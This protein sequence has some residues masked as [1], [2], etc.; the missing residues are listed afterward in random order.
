[1]EEKQKGEMSKHTHK[2]TNS[3]HARRKN[4]FISFLA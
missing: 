1:M 2:A 4:N 3:V